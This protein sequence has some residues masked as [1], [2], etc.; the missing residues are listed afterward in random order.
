MSFMKHIF[1]KFTFLS[2]LTRASILPSAPWIVLPPALSFSRQL[3][4]P[5]FLHFCPG[6]EI[7]WC[8]CK[9]ITHEADGT[10]CSVD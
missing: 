7:W 5:L 3:F 6:G 1:A 10:G 8:C 2:I 9:C 4:P